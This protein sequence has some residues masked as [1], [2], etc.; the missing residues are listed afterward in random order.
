MKSKR[1]CCKGSRCTLRWKNR[2]IEVRRQVEQNRT[3]VGRGLMWTVS[4]MK[5]RERGLY[6][7]WQSMFCTSSLGL[8]R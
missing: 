8:I 4:F 1:S 6:V 5:G 2:D 3:G 7:K